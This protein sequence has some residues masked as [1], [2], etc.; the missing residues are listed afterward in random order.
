M[1]QRCQLV[2]QDHTERLVN[3]RRVQPGHTPQS[4]LPLAHD[5][6]GILEQL[7]EVLRA[8]AHAIRS[9]SAS[10]AASS[11]AFG[12]MPHSLTVPSHSGVAGSR[13]PTAQQADIVRDFKQAWEAKDIDALN[14]VL[15]PDATAIADGGGLVSTEL[16]PIE[17]GEQIARVCVNIASRVPNL[18]LPERAVNGQPGLVAQQDGIP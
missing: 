8:V 11:I 16:R 10:P 6:Y 4:G 3:G 2:N 1:G 17:G 9:S 7:G 14:G 18:T 5:Q 12:S 13:N 15:G